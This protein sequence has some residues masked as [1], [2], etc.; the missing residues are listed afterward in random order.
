M[1]AQLLIQASD[2]GNPTRV[3]YEVL[4]INIDRNNFAPSWVNPTA[5]GY[6]STTQYVSPD[7]YFFSSKVL[8]TID[9][10][11]VIFTVSARDQDTTAP[12]NQV[13][14]DLVGDGNSPTFFDVNPSSGEIRLRSSLLQDSAQSY[15]LFLTAADNGFPV[16]KASQTATVVVDVLRNL[17]T[18]F[19]LNSPY[20]VTI[21]ETTF[22]GSSIFRVSASDN[23]QL[24]TFESVQFDIIG[25]DAA[26]VYFSVEPFS[27][28][29][30]VASDLSVNTDSI[31]YVRF[32][33]RDNGQPT[34]RSNTTLL[35]VT[36]LRNL[37]PPV[38]NPIQYT[39][40]ISD[41]TP[42]GTIITTVT[43][44]DSDT[45][46][47]HNIIRYSYRSGTAGAENLFY[48]NS[49][50]GEVSLSRAVQQDS[51]TNFYELF[52]TAT[53][54][55]IPPRSATVDARVQITVTR[56]QNDPFFINT[57][58]AVTIPESQSAG[59]SIF[60]ITASDSDSTAPFNVV[61]LRAIGDDLATVYFDLTNDG[62]VSVSSNLLLDTS[63]FYRLRVEA[64]DGG[65]PARSATALLSIN[66]RRNLA[67]P[68][69][70]Q[71]SYETTILETQSLGVNI[72]RVSATDADTKR[73]HNVTQY[74]I[75]NDNS[76]SLGE[77]YFLID[78]VTGEIYLRKSVL[79][80]DLGTPQYTFN[81]FA[82]DT[83]VPQLTSA[84]PASVT[85]NVVRN[86]NPPVFTQQ[87][88][89]TTI[90]NSLASGSE[91][92]V[93]T[94]IDADTRAP[95]NTVTY[96]IIGDGESQL[97]F[98]IGGSTGS[99]R[100]QQSILFRQELTYSVR[101]RARD[102]GSPRRSSTAVVT[103][104]VNRNLFDPVFS[105]A[106]YTIDISETT[107]PGTGILFVS[108]S[109]NDVAS[110]YNQVSYAFSAT[111]SV[112]RFFI[113]SNSGQIFV[114]RN[115]VGEV[116]TSFVVNVIASDNAPSPRS[117]APVKVTINI[118]RNNNPP[119]FINEPYS[120]SFTSSI[121]VG[122]SLLTVTATDSDL[123]V[124]FNQ[125]TYS[126]IGDDAAPTFFSINTNTGVISLLRSIASD[127]TDI[128]R[129]RVV[130]A[131]GGLP[132]KTD[133]TVVYFNIT[134]NLVAPEFNPSVY[135][136]SVSEDRA[137]GDPIL[138]VTARDGDVTAPNN[139]VT[140]TLTG[141][142]KALE[143][144]QVGS[145]SGQVSVLQPLYLDQD[146]TQTY[147]L[148]ITARDLGFPSRPAINTATVTVVVNR[149]NNPPVF[150]S[151]PYD[152]TISTPVASG[153]SVRAIT[154]TDADLAPF[155]TVTVQVIGD[156]S[157]PIYFSL[158][159][160]N[161]IRVSNTSSLNADTATFYRL[162]LL[163]TDFGYP[164]LTA[165]ATVG[166]TVRRNLF[167][168]RFTNVNTVRVT[169]PETA[170]V[171]TFI[172]DL[173]ATDSDTDSP[174]NQFQFSLV[175]DGDSL[176][177]FFV[178]P[179]D[180][181]VTLLQSV[182][183]TLASGYR[184]RVRVTDGGEPQLSSETFVEVTV[185]RDTENLVFTLPR[186]TVDISE[187]LGVNQ[188]VISVVAQPQDAVT[189][190]ITGYSDGP[191]YFN[192]S[193]TAGTIFVKTD[194]RS[195]K[196]RKPSYLLGVEAT[197]AFQAGVKTATADVE[198]NVRR[199]DNPPIFSREIYSVAISEYT[200]LGSSVVQLVANDADTQDVL[201]YTMVPKAGV[202]DFF[203]LG[204][205]TGLISLRTLLLGQTATRYTFDVLV[206]DQSDPERTDTATVDV[207]VIRDTF[208]PRFI[209]VPYSTV[210]GFNTAVGTSIFRVT[211]TDDDLV[212]S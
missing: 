41:T 95:F 125:V 24:N 200:S 156:D 29:V 42:L 118:L 36:I 106:E 65:T 192:I 9:Y 112:D 90:D 191:D 177:Y 184:L 81:A 139:Q 185:V 58:Y 127:F 77:E 187:N 104:N 171:G 194:L 134:R 148:V 119:Q 99:I 52:I 172:A 60:R 91:V 82:R 93:V 152:V 203:Y 22:V 101:V 153:T 4:T 76:N 197:R 70:V 67:A 117:S 18:P 61:S 73:P 123:R 168:P 102:G 44:T 142:S 126:I 71:N 10:S 103:V 96:D 28:I 63:T 178:N 198:I 98:S 94:A 27:G 120:A 212:V 72:L 85:V 190:R 35:T 167:P 53:D 62:V 15:T 141:N 30:R 34:P 180:G 79:N 45:S 33:A 16:E 196:N 5:P 31:Y 186:Y 68:V 182:E 111:T 155:N 84:S 51:L 204:P 38:F 47:P 49:I 207:T 147:S 57:P 20:A 78:A 115:L 151:T 150:L 107:A 149:N 11:T 55:G 130:A 48:V 165:T 183:N 174:N 19:F 170:A 169:I 160:D 136:A 206:S 201:Q 3:D 105:Q 121:A 188:F 116:A 26:P 211:A 40:V 145:S 46:A 143:Y 175:G 75:S 162:R 128:Y 54:E 74:Y 25:D 32:R 59:S 17:N 108:A 154:V 89:A 6:T 86:L 159:N 7:S 164:S 163:A 14:Y 43:A 1:S 113:D 133:T 138:Q 208:A 37:A 114:R 69:F 129:V 189:Y 161:V 2:G 181:R 195:D 12:Y 209:N 205:S 158:G 64:R 157:A 131:D 66:V 109:D 83:G 146:Q 166:I 132:A 135:T 21:P 210:V 137:V 8:E 124:P 179:L 80:D 176:T 144:F 173:N 56:N 140:Y 199:N 23:D 97:F 13:T 88:Y 202:T 87:N 50:T 39:G 122:T 193:S 100:L 92:L 110:P